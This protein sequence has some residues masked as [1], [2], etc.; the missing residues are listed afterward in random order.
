M[1]CL[2]H[3]KEDIIFIFSGVEAAATNHSD[4]STLCLL[5]DRWLSRNKLRVGIYPH[6]RLQ[7]LFAADGGNYLVPPK[8]A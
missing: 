7:I 8:L 4:Y 3:V 5:N 1:Q 6:L 2:R